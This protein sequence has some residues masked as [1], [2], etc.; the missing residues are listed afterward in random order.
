MELL[1]KIIFK[2]RLWI[3]R[4]LGFSRFLYRS[5][6]HYQFNKKTEYSANAT[7]YL[8]GRPNPG[9][10]IGHQMANWIAGYHYAKQFGVHFCHYPFSNSFSGKPNSNWEGFLNFGKGEI[11]IDEL[12]SKGYRLVRLPKFDEDDID[13]VNMVRNIIL[14]YSKG[15]I[16]FLLEQDQFW[17]AQF[18]EKY[19]LRKKFMSNKDGKR[20]DLFNENAINIAVHIRRGDIVAGDRTNPNL[21]MR[22]QQTRYFYNILNEICKMLCGQEVRIVIFTQG[23]KSEY[24]EFLQIDPSIEIAT[25]VD[26]QESFW[27]MTQADILV[28]SKSSFSYK[29]ALLSDGVIICPSKFWHG[30]P[31]E[32]NWI[33]V[34]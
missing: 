21:T 20:T 30:Y 18:E 26:A 31:K 4:K 3:Y 25:D 19:E 22:F 12:K 9:A 5:F 1:Q 13:Q 27:H 29:P 8:T 10:G 14:S 15:R 11:G 28:T 24:S 32:R 16:C 17:F 23:E 34:Q 2:G 6:W 33:E 7:L